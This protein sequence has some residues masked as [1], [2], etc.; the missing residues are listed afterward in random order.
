MTI[1]SIH[2]PKTGGTTFLELLRRNFDS[3]LL[4]DYGLSEN[5][6]ELLNNGSYDCVHGHFISDKYINIHNAEYIVWLREP[7]QRLYSHFHFWKKNKFPHSLLW[8]RFYFEKWTFADFALHPAFKNEQ[9]KYVG[10]IPIENYSFIGITEYYHESIDLFCSKYGF[11]IDTQTLPEHRVNR[12]DKESSVYTIEDGSLMAEIY[13][14]H[15]N[16]Y[17]LYL[18]GL[19]IFHL[20]Y[21]ST[22]NFK[23]LQKFTN[24]IKKESDKS[25]PF[26]LQKFLIKKNADRI[27]ATY[28]FGD[29]WPVNFW[30][31]FRRDLVDSYLDR[32]CYDS[33]NTVILL[34]PAA[35]SELR[36]KNIEHYK[37]FL[38]DLNYLLSRLELK[39]LNSIARIGYAWDGFAIEG[40]RGH[41]CF[42]ILAGGSAREYAKDAF[43]EIW[44]VCSNYN[45]F[46]YGFITWED[47][48]MFAWNRATRSNDAKRR[49]YAEELDYSNNSSMVPQIHEPEFY[50]YLE[51]IDQKFIDLFYDLR[52]VFP[53]L[54]AE[55]RIDSTPFSD[56]KGETGHFIHH[57][58]FVETDC[59]VIGSYFATYMFGSENP[60]ADDVMRGLNIAHHNLISDAPQKKIFIDQLLLVIREKIYNHF[61]KLS[62]EEFANVLLRLPEWLSKH[63]IGYATWSFDDYLWDILFNG[64][65]RYG[66]MGWACV[67][68]PKFQD[69]ETTRY[70][71]LSTG[72]SI[73]GDRLKHFSPWVSDG[74]LLVDATVS[75]NVEII[76]EVNEDYAVTLTSNDFVPVQ[77]R[78]KG[79][80]IFAFNGMS[81]YIKVSLKKG[82]ARIYRIGLGRE[83]ISNGGHTIS[84]G[85]TE[86]AFLISKLNYSYLN[87]F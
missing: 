52:D 8:R 2:V 80:S 60:S 19:D 30:D 41:I 70:V 29:G 21:E 66:L 11:N 53:R 15:K 13:A 57:R 76:V 68:S 77:A 82:S 9:S 85:A 67:G 87:N 25:I 31:T 38:E 18:K 24:I 58:Q 36:K 40:D 17:E 73:Q 45:K 42:S 65:F 26:S 64:S 47:M 46:L 1:I 16:D 7:I 48:Q 59:D 10:S 37:L 83:I 5:K 35:I 14:F 20:R 69:N 43:R 72:D 23:L 12:T 28:Y 79:M 39:G 56:D 3:K 22:F 33:F 63:C 61:P 32:I 55:V 75:D 74:M 44:E 78:S 4:V 50:N 62:T 84:S 54:S 86:T 51:F 34:I 6:I 81:K 27:A 71:E 49:I